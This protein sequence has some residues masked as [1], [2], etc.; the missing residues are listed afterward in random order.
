[1]SNI[2]KRLYIYSRGSNNGVSFWEKKLIPVIT[3]LISLT[4]C[5]YFI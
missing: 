1:M 4:F 2:Y 3:Y 5:H